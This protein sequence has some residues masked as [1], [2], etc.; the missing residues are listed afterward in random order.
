MVETIGDPVRILLDNTDH[1]V[2]PKSSLEPAWTSGS[3]D[4]SVPHT[5]MIIKQNPE[6]QYLALYSFSVTYPD[7]PTIVATSAPSNTETENPT[8]PPETQPEL[9]ATTRMVIAGAV[10]GTVCLGLLGVLGIYFW[11]R[12]NK[13]DRTLNPFRK[14]EGGTSPFQSTDALFG[15]FLIRFFFS[16]LRPNIFSS[17]GW[18]CSV[19]G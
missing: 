13:H 15:E 3:L 12:R 19:R 8:K 18:R 7:L 16:K 17:N 5:I 14:V 1:V 10:V 2:T 11:R 6:D 9:T 4:P